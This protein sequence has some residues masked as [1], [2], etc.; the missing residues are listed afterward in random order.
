MG[1]GGGGVALGGPGP[2]GLVG[3]S[4]GDRVRRRR[5]VVA[6]PLV[7]PRLVVLLRVA[8]RAVDRDQLTD[9][10]LAV[11]GAA[12][13]DLVGRD[14]EIP[15]VTGPAHPARRTRMLEWE[16]L[17]GQVMAVPHVTDRIPAWPGVRIGPVQD[18][19]N[20]RARRRRPAGE[21]ARALRRGAAR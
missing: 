7:F 10:L 18:G 5:G 6:D 3:A 17:G 21:E 12:A 9:D 13:R 11:R 19:E 2:S 20:G 14:V 1:E 4:P 15:P 8:A 16:A